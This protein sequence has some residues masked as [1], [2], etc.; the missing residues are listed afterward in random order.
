MR[1]L[2]AALAI[3]AL[4]FGLGAAQASTVTLDYTGAPATFSSYDEDGFTTSVDNGTLQN[5]FFRP[6]EAYVATQFPATVTIARTDMMAFSAASI[7]LVYW[8][9]VP[10]GVTATIMGELADGSMVSQTISG[11][12]T[13]A[14][15]ALST[16]F[17]NIVALSFAQNG[18]S[19][20]TQPGTL[21]AFGFDNVVVAPVPLP[22]T[23]VLLLVAIG[24]VAAMRRKRGT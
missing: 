11:I 13:L 22:A 15:Y 14:T 12:T 6:G 9:N 23:G 3:L 24:G 5:G 20:A 10:A 1:N 18:F 2:L 16:D 8:S 19:D 21:G 4:P 7:D 17:S